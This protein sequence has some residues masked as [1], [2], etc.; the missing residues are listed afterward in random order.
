M[1]IHNKYVRGVVVAVVYFFSFLSYLLLSIFST[2]FLIHSRTLSLHLWY[3]QEANCWLLWLRYGERESERLKST[4]LDSTQLDSTPR[5]VM[6]CYWYANESE[7]LCSLCSNFSCLL[8]SLCLCLWFRLL[9]LNSN[10]IEK[11]LWLRIRNRY[12]NIVSRF[13]F[14]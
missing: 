3:F 14:V 4:W 8:F 12:K 5:W 10:E 13:G 9:L 2:G 1:Y 11:H 7:I 6:F